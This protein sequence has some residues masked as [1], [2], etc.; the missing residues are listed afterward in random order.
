MHGWTYYQT[1]D[2]AVVPY[3]EGSPIYRDGVL[4]HLYY[5]TKEEG[6]LEKVFHEDGFNLDKF[7]TF[8]EKRKTLQCLCHVRE[9]KT[10]IPVGYCW[11]DNPSGVDGQR[12]V[13]CAFCFFK[14]AKRTARDLG[15]LGLA[16]WFMD[17]RIDIVHGVILD[18]NT[19]AVNY[20]KHLGFKEVA[21]VP[22]WKYVKEKLT[23]VRVV[24]LEASDYLPG[25]DNWFETQKA[26]AVEK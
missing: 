18:W 1:A 7:V 22:K 17:L 13:L 23:G 6:N 21:Y 4:P 24:Q 3:M 20:A 26:V 9:D 8:F 15:R 12:G 25:F 19:P 2:L 16:Y 11:V 10:L 5:K 14:D